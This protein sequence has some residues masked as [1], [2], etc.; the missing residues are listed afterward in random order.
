MSGKHLK[1]CSMFL[2]TRKMQTKTFLRFYLTFFR[3]AKIN[4]MGDRSCGKSMCQVEYS[5]IVGRSVNQYNHYI[6]QY[7]AF[8]E[9][10]KSIQTLFIPPLGIKQRI[11][12]PITRIKYVHCS[13]IHIVK[14]LEI[15]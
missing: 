5:S 12:H 15:T 4:G 3:M 10:W 7:S 9:N 14:K 6:I 11:F 13:F 2:A 1:K 8:L